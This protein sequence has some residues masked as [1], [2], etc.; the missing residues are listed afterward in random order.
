[1]LHC[2]TIRYFQLVQRHQFPNFTRHQELYRKTRF[3]EHSAMNSDSGL[4]P[5][6]A[7]TVATALNEDMGLEDVTA[8]LIPAGLIASAKVVARES[9]TICGAAWFDEVY[10]KLNPSVLVD[11]C[12]RDGDQVL[13]HD[14]V[15]E[16]RGPAAVLLYGERTAL[17]FLQTLSG[18]ATLTRKF[19]EAVSGTGVRI[20]DT[21]KTLPGLRNAQKYAVRVG[22]GY[23]HRFGLYDGVLIKENHLFMSDSLDSMIRKLPSDRTDDLLVEVEVENLDELRIAMKCGINRILLDNFTVGQIREAVRMADGQVELE[24]SG[25]FNLE[26]IRETAETGVDFI[27][28]GGLTKD[29]Q[30]VDFSMLFVD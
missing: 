4:P 11:W 3:D 8:T 15:C 23:N 14:T 16:L 24:A 25:S 29:V 5:D 28:V 20:L 30:A 12:A 10:R 26:N 1:M 9:A 21:R 27:S 13:E 7:S 2:R 19:V 17:N 6:I 18:T 22:G